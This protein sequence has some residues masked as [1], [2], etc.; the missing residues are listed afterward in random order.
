[1]ERS[2]TVTFMHFVILFGTIIDP[3]ANKSVTILPNHH[4][5][6]YAYGIFTFKD[7]EK[8]PF[9]FFKLV[10]CAV[11]VLFYVHFEKCYMKCTEI[12]SPFAPKKYTESS[13]FLLNPTH[14]L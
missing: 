10:V 8:P 2:G 13:F 9:L 11:C 1:M 4:S 14:K 7:A 5:P 12:K 6:I 3:Y